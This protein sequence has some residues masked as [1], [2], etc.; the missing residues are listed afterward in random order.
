M[1][2]FAQ[3]NIFFFPKNYLVKMDNPPL[4]TQ[5]EMYKELEN[6]KTLVAGEEVYLISA[7]WLQRFKRG[8]ESTCGPINNRQ[9]LINDKLSLE[10]KREKIDYEIITKDMWETLHSW[11]QGGPTIK[12]QVVNTDTGPKVIL[13]ELKLKCYFNSFKP[14]EITTNEYVKGK[15]LREQVMKMFAVPFN[16][17][18]RLC[19]YYQYEFRNEIKD[20]NELRKYNLINGQAIYLEKKSNGKWYSE[21]EKE[22]FDIFGDFYPWLL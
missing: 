19:D 21:K 13:S 6:E 9:F 17:E 11:Y 10:R 12:L 16:E 18:T 3:K 1:Q 22:N 20:E 4:E 14:K 8:T 7:Q 2:N 15:D 5:R